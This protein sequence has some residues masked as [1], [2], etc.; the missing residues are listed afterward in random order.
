VSTSIIIQNGLSDAEYTDS[1]G[2]YANN[3]ITIASSQSSSE[4]GT[5]DASSA[6]NFVNNGF[7][8]VQ[9]QLLKHL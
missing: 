2:G 7:E 6:I 8:S 5:V 1:V 4:A 3:E 9:Y